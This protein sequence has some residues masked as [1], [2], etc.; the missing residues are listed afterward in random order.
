MSFFSFTSSKDPKGIL[1]E[2]ITDLAQQIIAT[3][4]YGTN[5][6]LV[7]SSQFMISPLSAAAVIET[8]QLGAFMIEGAVTPMLGKRINFDIDVNIPLSVTQ[9]VVATVMASLE[10]RYRLFLDSNAI[11]T[12]P[13]PMLTKANVLK[14]YSETLEWAGEL[15]VNILST[16]VVNTDPPGTFLGLDSTTIILGLDTNVWMDITV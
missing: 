1:T 8:S 6:N 15:R 10:Q 5:P 2:L 16:S 3:G 14:A 12:D 7:F 11:Y 13:L 9:D 4:V